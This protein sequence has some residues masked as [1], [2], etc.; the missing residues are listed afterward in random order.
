MALLGPWLLGMYGREFG[1]AYPVLLILLVSVLFEAI[2]LS[3]YQVIQSHERMW[4]SFIAIALP[5]DGMVAALALGLTPKFGAM[6]LALT[7]ACGGIF[8]CAAT[9][10]AARI[11]TTSGVISSK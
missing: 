8:A 5:R 2:G 10:V 6:G 7:Y 1:P 3:V 4:L 11:I 9:I